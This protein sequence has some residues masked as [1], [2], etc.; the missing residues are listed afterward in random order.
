MHVEGFYST[1]SRAFRNKNEGNIENPDGTMKVFPTLLDG[2]V[3]LVDDIAANRG[4]TLSAFI[5]KYAPPN[6]NNTSMY[7]QVVSQ[8]SGIGEQ[9][10]L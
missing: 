1:N 6:E 7:L 10:I 3:A 2:F 4:K 8:L 9:E 5:A